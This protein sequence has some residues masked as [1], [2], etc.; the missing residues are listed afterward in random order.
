MDPSRKPKVPAPAVRVRSTVMAGR[1]R[2]E[3]SLPGRAAPVGRVEVKLGGPQAEIVNLR[4]EPQFRKQQ[5]GSNLVADALKLARTR[6][7]QSVSLVARP[8][9]GSI[10]PQQLTSMYRRLGFRS[11]GF[12]QGGTRMLFGAAPPA[13]K[14]R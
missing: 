7:A 13:A 11:A 6:G 12:S 10:A 3:A 1:A 8:S 4:V 14:K 5:I 2:L 9:D